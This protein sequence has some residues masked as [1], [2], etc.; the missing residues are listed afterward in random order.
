VLPA[1]RPAPT[2]TRRARP[3]LARSLVVLL[4]SAALVA[5]PAS[6]AFAAPSVEEREQV[7]DLTFPVAEP[8]TNVSFIDDY[9]HPRSGGRTHAATDVMAPKHRPVH[10][11]VGGTLGFVPVTEPSYGWMIDINA[12]DGLRY[13]YI[14]LN[15]DTPVR[16]SSGG[17]SDD[18]RGGMEHAYAPK[19]VEAIRT[20]GTAR[21]LRVDRGELIGW[22]GD[23]GN[24]K[25][26]AAHLHFE[27]HA[28]NAQGA[29]R[30]NPYRSLKAALAEGDVP[31]TAGY[32]GRFR[33]VDP[34][35]DHAAAIEQLTADAIAF[36]CGSD[37]YCPNVS[38]TRGEVAAFLASAR[39]LATGA[40]S[41]PFPDVAPSH[42]HAGAIAA[43]NTAG[44]LEGYVD[45]RFRPDA[46]LSRAQLASVLVRAFDLAPATS[47]SSPFTDVKVGQTHAAA[48]I[49]TSEAGLTVGCQDG[50][51]YCGS[52][53]VTRAQTAS[54]VFRARELP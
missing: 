40:T 50:T 21:G 17:W 45:G 3:P 33:D 26:G 36:G 38:I 37:R 14:H 32:P 10:A 27:M 31:G 49:A 25:G 47:T 24:A 46:P 48:I 5:G 29:Y 53:S 52:R 8:G 9:F 42:P 12:D 35:S 18:D 30:I 39:S 20:T 44:I 34:A 13:S 54:F 11:A 28:T 2:S 41:A 43:V 7:V 19:I 15:N 4:S 22:V 23:S 51:T 6:A 1:S 16:T